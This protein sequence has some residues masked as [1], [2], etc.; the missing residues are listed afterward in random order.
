MYAR[1]R[2]AETYGQLSAT[3][4]V[5]E[6]NIRRCFEWWLLVLDTLAFPDK[7][8][9]DWRTVFAEHPVPVLPLAAPFQHVRLIVDGTPF[10]VEKPQIPDQQDYY[11]NKYHKYCVKT[12]L[13][14]GTEGYI[15]FMSAIYKGHVHDKRIFDDAQTLAWSKRPDPITGEDV[16][17]WMMGDLGYVGV[18]STRFVLPHKRKPH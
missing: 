1:I 15:Y 6:E 9:H 18:V 10:E 5:P 14:V 12:Q 2:S 7:M 11:S 3:F 16:Y 17:E 8:N 13:V 4:H